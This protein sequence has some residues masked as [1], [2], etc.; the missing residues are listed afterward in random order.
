MLISVMKINRRQR[1]LKI[2]ETLG[3]LVRLGKDDTSVGLNG[4]P[5]AINKSCLDA[6]GATGV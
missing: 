5:K 2:S 6:S 3:G 4:T 1:W